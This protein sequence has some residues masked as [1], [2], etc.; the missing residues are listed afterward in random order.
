M[1]LCFP[2]TGAADYQPEDR[3]DGAF[4]RRFSSLLVDDEL[5]ID[6]SCG[7]AD[8]CKETGLDLSRV[9]VLL[10]THTHDDH[11]RPEAIRAA[12][13][14]HPPLLCAEKETAKQI[15]RETGECVA[16]PLFE[17]TALGRFFVTA[18][19]ANHAVE[20]RLQTPVHYVIEDG[21]KTLF[22][23]CDGASLP[24]RTWRALRAFR[25]DAM[26]LDGTFGAIENDE[27]LFE[28]NTLFAV[29]QMA[30]VFR[31]AGLLKETG[32]LYLS[33]ISQYSNFPH[34]ELCRKAALFGAAVAY[35]G[36]EED[37]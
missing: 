9:E 27:R 19:P 29:E 17:R 18:L 6:C 37:V 13:G 28:H 3:Q 2:G 14:A 36:L 10:F 15:R 30:A 4:F 12:F 11:Y 5:L 34:G 32:K 26:V 35:D 16:L 20:N 23:G 24:T 8:F 22:Y 25:F 21:E 33:H 7:V 31:K 1:K